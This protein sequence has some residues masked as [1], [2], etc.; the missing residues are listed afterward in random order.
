MANRTQA[1]A[2]TLE[3]VL[4]ERCKKSKTQLNAFLHELKDAGFRSLQLDKEV[5]KKVTE[6]L[7][8]TKSR[9]IALKSGLQWLYE[10]IVF[11][12]GD[13]INYTEY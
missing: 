8:E 5:I 1:V 6:F 4:D 7:L 9:T 11:F 12:R 2:D 13:F 3:L 10:F